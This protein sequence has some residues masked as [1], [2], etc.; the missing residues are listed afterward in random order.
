MVFLHVEMC[1]RDMTIDLL[2]KNAKKKN[3]TFK[4]ISKK[5]PTCNTQNIYIIYRS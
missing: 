3:I 2:K 1:L 4:I 5:D